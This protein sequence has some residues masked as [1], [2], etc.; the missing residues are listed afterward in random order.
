[1]LISA[2]SGG[3]EIVSASEDTRFYDDP[4]CLAGDWT[5]HR[6]DA[7]A[8]VKLAGAGWTDAQTASFAQPA[9]ARTAMGS[10]ITAFAAAAEARAADRAGRVLTFDDI[11]H[12][13]GAPR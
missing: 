12:L 10:G 7:R 5:A 9:G 3:G 6:G 4:G 8:F 11:V 2:E 1:M 13:S